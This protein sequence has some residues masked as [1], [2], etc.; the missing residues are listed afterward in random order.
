ML[1]SV[2]L[3][4]VNAMRCG[5]KLRIVFRIVTGNPCRHRSSGGLFSACLSIGDVLKDDVRRVPYR[6]RKNCEYMH[7][8]MKPFV[9]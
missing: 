7:L 9:A 4:Y 1:A 2:F 8:D 3:A 5:I 6:R